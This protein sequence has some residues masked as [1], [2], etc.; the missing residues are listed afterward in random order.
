MHHIQRKILQQLMYAAS[1][2]YAKMRPAGVESNQ[3][4]YHLDQLIHEGLIAKDRRSYSLTDKGLALVDR[5]SHKDIRV[6]LQ[7]H[8]VTS[9]YI[10]N[11]Q[12][13]MLLYEHRFQPYL[14]L[15]GPPQG[16]LHYAEHIADAA[17]RELFE[18]T[19]LVDVPLKH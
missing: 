16:R 3:F 18:K 14:N 19:G 15:Y 5:S 11:D 7:P 10:T 1:L 12:G 13:Q 8:I 9:L 6:R 17:Q 4:A 2:N